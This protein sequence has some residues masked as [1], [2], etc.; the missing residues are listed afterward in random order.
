ME[1]AINDLTSRERYKVLTGLVLPRR[2]DQCH[3]QRSVRIA[4]TL[5]LH[6]ETLCFHRARN[7]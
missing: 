5:P 3:S 7:R 1:Y 2:F 6:K 4:F